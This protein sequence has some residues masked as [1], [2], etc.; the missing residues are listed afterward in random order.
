VLTMAPLVSTDI[1][2]NQTT[3]NFELRP[4][5][6]N[7]T[8]IIYCPEPIGSYSLVDASFCVPLALR[9][10]KNST[11]FNANI[12]DLEPATIRSMER[13]KREG[14]FIGD[15][16][17]LINFEDNSA[18]FI[19]LFILS[20]KERWTIYSG[21]KIVDRRSLTSKEISSPTG[22]RFIHL[23]LEPEHLSRAAARLLDPQK[24]PIVN[25]CTKLLM[26]YLE[27]EERMKIR[28]YLI[29][30]S[31]LNINNDYNAE[32]WKEMVRGYCEIMANP[33]FGKRGDV[34]WF[35]GDESHTAHI[36]KST[37][38]NQPFQIY[39][40]GENVMSAMD[41]MGAID[42]ARNIIDR[43]IREIIIKLFE[44]SR[45]S[46]WGARMDDIARVPV[47]NF[48][49]HHDD[50][51]NSLEMQES[52]QE[53]PIAWMDLDE[54]ISKITTRIHSIRLR[55]EIARTTSAS[56]SFNNDE[57]FKMKSLINR[58]KGVVVGTTI[59]METLKEM[60]PFLGA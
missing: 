33:S 53:L 59:G 16:P 3:L 37:D 39:I 28:N 55:K 5:H 38:P 49:Q 13:L 44:P 30:L 54:V 22:A 14:N 6:S 34:E 8:D 17:N 24:H 26:H 10:G 2:T 57:S 40:D 12:R 42:G 60:V 9:S 43:N 23:S 4:L 32:R 18:A 29:L 11:V 15:L 27:P 7:E 50:I 19:L 21:D 47:E 51:V 36:V 41:R 25:K 52:T 56:Q 1:R 48:I 58:R 35:Y 46:S 31:R 20:S 45:I